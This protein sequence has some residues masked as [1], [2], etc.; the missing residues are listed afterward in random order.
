KFVPREE[1]KSLVYKEL[2]TTDQ[3]KEKPAS[4]SLNDRGHGWSGGCHGYYE[5]LPDVC[6]Y[7]SDQTWNRRN[8]YML[9]ISRGDNYGEP[10][11]E[12]NVDINTSY[13]SDPMHLTVTGT[14]YSM[15]EKP[16][17]V[18]IR[19]H[20]IANCTPPL[21]SASRVTTRPNIHSPKVPPH[22]STLDKL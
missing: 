13:Q 5:E 4:P 21:R 18:P 11:H 2:N 10:L 22:S 19:E 17:S 20:S 7:P 8:P 15:I 1:S 14:T 9:N 12:P 6:H 16:P 3:F